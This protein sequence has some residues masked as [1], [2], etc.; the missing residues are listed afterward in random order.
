MTKN[1]YGILI[2]NRFDVR[3]YFAAIIAEITRM[4]ARFDICVFNFRSVYEGFRNNNYET[5]RLIN[6]RAIL[7]TYV[8]INSIIPTTGFY[9]K[10]FLNFNTPIFFRYGEKKVLSISRFGHRAGL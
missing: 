5:K 4:L 2:N 8:Y 6:L 1:K 3:D 9:L 10:T 7:Q